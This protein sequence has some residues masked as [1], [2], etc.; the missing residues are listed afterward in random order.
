MAGFGNYFVPLLV[1]ADDM[2]FPQVN[3]INLE[4]LG[5]S[6]TQQ[7]Q[8]AVLEAGRKQQGMNVLAGL[9]NS[10]RRYAKQQG[11]LQLWL[12]RTF[13]ADG[14]LIRVGGAWTT[15]RGKRIRIHAADLVDGEIVPTLVQPEG[16][17]RMDFESWRNGAR[18]ADGEWFT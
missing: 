11:R 10:K 5:Q 15:F 1:G 9:F 14:R 3:G 7:P 17:A 12:L 8:A 18:P 13:I 16:K 4:L 2:V 6:T